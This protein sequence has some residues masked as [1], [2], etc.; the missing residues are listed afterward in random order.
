M[1]DVRLNRLARRGVAVAAAAALAAG[2]GAA[3]ADATPARASGAN[4]P[5][6]QG[7]VVPGGFASWGELARQQDRLTRAAARIAATTQLADKQVADNEYA[8]IVAAPENRELRV[9]WKGRPSAQ[10]SSLIGALRRSVPIK[11]YGARFSERELV[12]EANRLVER[13]QGTIT[14]AGP[15]VDGSGVTATVTPGTGAPGLT[16]GPA[17]TAS[18]AAASVPVTLEPGPAPVAGTR[19]DDSAPWYGGGSYIVPGSSCSTGFA[20]MAGG[21]PQ[22]LSAGHCGSLN[23][24]A[25]DP[26]GETIGTVKSMNKGRDVLLI[27]ASTAG[28]VFNNGGGSEFSNAVI[29]A[30]ANFVGNWVC[31]SGAPSGTQCGI[32]VKAVNQTITLGGIGT[33]VTGQVK[34]EKSDRTNAAGNG[35][36]GG[37][38]EEVAPDVSQVYARGTFTAFDGT[39]NPVPCTGNI[40]SGPGRTCSWR[41]WYEDIV[42]GMGAFGATIITG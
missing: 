22:M 20:V 1:D 36:S 35:D 12:R 21:K 10:V 39:A 28:Q 17:A 26:T 3:A 41:I 4:R 32:Q 40:P 37:P 7:G 31:T 9:Y 24:T 34:A 14:T 29:G 16:A 33:V 13:G 42:A 8:E 15:N 5:V 38:V 11:L 2:G 18:V 6:V 30:R 19:F 27:Q 23:D 25:T